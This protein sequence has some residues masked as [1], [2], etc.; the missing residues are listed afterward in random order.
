MD[1]KQQKWNLPSKEDGQAFVIRSQAAEKDLCATLDLLHHIHQSIPH[2]PA[3][4]LK[5]LIKNHLTRFK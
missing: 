2:Q 1:I 4:K 5:G 3:G